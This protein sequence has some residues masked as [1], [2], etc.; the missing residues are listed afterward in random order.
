MACAEPGGILA[1]LEAQNNEMQEVL[2]N[3]DSH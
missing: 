3:I 1:T 2:V